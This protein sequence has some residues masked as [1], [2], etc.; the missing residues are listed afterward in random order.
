MVLEREKERE[1]EGGEGERRRENA[2][3][4]QIYEMMSHSVLNPP[5][6]PYPYSFFFSCAV[7]L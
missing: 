4:L 2:S 3:L 6:P 5:V 1:R 7:S